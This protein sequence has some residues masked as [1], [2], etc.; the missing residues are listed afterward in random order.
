MRVR[1]HRSPAFGRHCLESDH[2]RA[3]AN[4]PNSSNTSPRL[5]DS[6][7]AGEAPKVRDS[8]QSSA[9]A[10][11]PSFTTY[12]G[13][14]GGSIAVK[15]PRSQPT[16]NLSPPN[17]PAPRRSRL[18][19]LQ[20]L[21]GCAALLVVFGH[22]MAIF[23]GASSTQAASEP[24]ISGSLGVSSFFVVSG[25]LMVYVHGRDF[26]GN[27][28]TKNFYARRIAR[29]IPLYWLITVLY[30]AKQIYFHNDTLG[31]LVRSLLFFPYQPKGDL[32]RPVLG[33]GWTLNYEMAFY[34]I[35]GLALFFARGIWIVYGV[36]G[37]LALLGAVGLFG[38]HNVFSF[39]SNPIILYFLA[40]VSVG[41]VQPK[42]KR[43]PPF[44]VAFTAC[45][46]ILSIT[47]LAAATSSIAQNY[48]PFVLPIAAVT[49][50]SITALA[51][52]D[53]RRSW[54]RRGA[55]RVGD[56]SY[57]IY[58]THSFVIAPAA[59]LGVARLLPTMP[60]SVFVCLMLIATT[61]V[62]YLVYRF[63]EQPLI[64]VWTRTF[65]T[66]RAARTTVTR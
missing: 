19:A 54:V 29:I 66:K 9:R 59:K 36:F 28:A 57:S 3:I 25:F 45:I 34:L 2:A 24:D 31:H 22:S 14:I 43:G 37:T 41:L 1:V 61:I 40:G 42:L 20:G 39:W 18:D 10:G 4:I 53:S 49:A 27:G 44:V 23:R 35:F 38:P 46:A 65:I 15:P 64:K 58:L 33:L 6:P 5:V 55:K 8:K 13:A 7:V 26:G 60:L 63:V 16:G 11:K 12:R 47:A 50:V 51:K 56:A 30:G 32:W 62:G 21:R 48:M 52:E 17:A